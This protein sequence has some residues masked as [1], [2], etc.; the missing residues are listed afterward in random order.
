MLGLDTAFLGV[1]LMLG[2]PPGDP[3]GCAAEFRGWFEAARNG[4]LE[5]PE[6]VARRARRFR[7]V[8]VGGFRNGPMP[9]YFAQNAA[10]LRAHDVPRRRIHFFFPSS[11]WSVDEN[12]S[13]VREGLIRIAAEGS[14]RLVVIAHSRGA[15]DALAFALHE[16]QFV[17]DRVEALFLVQGTFGGTGLADY[18]LGTGEPMDGRMP[19][20]H[21]VLA[22][23]IGTLERLLLKRGGHGGLAGL[24]RAESRAYWRRIL[25]EHAEAIPVV[26]PKVYYVAS[27][28]RSSHLALF[29]RAMS[30]YLGAYYGPNDGVVA[31]ADQSLPGLGTIL[32]VLEAGHA[33][34]TRRSPAT[35]VGRRSRRALIQAILMAV[36]RSGPA[37]EE[38]PRGRTR[39]TPS[40]RP[41][42][43]AAR[44]QDPTATRTCGKA[45]PAD[46]RR[47]DCFDCCDG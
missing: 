25:H 15:C 9:G 2:S 14:E 21:R 37:A 39:I 19:R 33:D 41:G 13:A 5:I 4:T 34:L 28:A 23:A 45:Q 38:T 7:Y 44:R 30:W 42:G 1:A 16:P 29:L 17:R 32:G 40:Q 35:R 26:G 47:S 31:V 11:R 43:K 46:D 10:E 3:R 22:A 36:G 6:P 8:F 27:Q 20:G 24:S 12:R 18:L